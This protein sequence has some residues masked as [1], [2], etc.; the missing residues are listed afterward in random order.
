MPTFSPSFS[1]TEIQTQ[2]NHFNVHQYED[3]LRGGHQNN[4]FSY[5][6]PSSS[7]EFYGEGTFVSQ[8]M[9]PMI[10]SSSIMDSREDEQNEK[11]FMGFESHFGTDSSSHS[12]ENWEEHESKSTRSY[13]F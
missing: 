1:Q 12:T 3:I 6:H 7:Q 4:S 10:P 13:F 5:G 2:D 9:T 8:D 11:D